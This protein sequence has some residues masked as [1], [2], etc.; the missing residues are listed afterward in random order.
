MVMSYCVTKKHF[1][2]CHKNVYVVSQENISSCDTRRH[3]HKVTSSCKGTLQCSCAC[4]GW[5]ARAVQFD[6]NLGSSAQKRA[7]FLFTCPCGHVGTVVQP[8]RDPVLKDPVLILGRHFKTGSF[9]TGSFCHDIALYPIYTPLSP[10][11]PTPRAPAGGTGGWVH[12]G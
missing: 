6:I 8:A 12:G 10:P 9:K 3:N 5:P 2:F 4:I 1:F 7:L 11:Y